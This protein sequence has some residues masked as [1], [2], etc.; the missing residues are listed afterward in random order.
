[1]VKYG[2][3]TISGGDG[4]DSLNGGNDNDEL[5]GGVGDDLINGGEGFDTGNGGL[6]DDTFDLENPYIR[7]DDEIMRCTIVHPYFNARM[8]I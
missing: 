6:G 7:T 5:S 8:K 1:M 3:D 2:N 4:N